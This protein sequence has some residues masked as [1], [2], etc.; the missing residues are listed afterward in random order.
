MSK[1]FKTRRRVEF[2]DTDAAGIVHF[3]VFFVYMEQ[4]EHEFLRS[5]GLSVMMH[6]DGRFVGFP[7]VNAQCNYRSPI[8][9]E[10]MV[11]IEMTV[12]RIGDK[13]ITYGFQFRCGERDV[14]DG[15]ITA[16]C[17]EVHGDRPVGVT[18]PDQIL[19]KVRPYLIESDS[20]AS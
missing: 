16:A 8:Q 13:S 18:I 17:C 9:F 20:A 2:R 7:R 4:T 11:D 19:E 3:S 6:V 10:D 5:L 14:A 15:S 12:Q 1:S